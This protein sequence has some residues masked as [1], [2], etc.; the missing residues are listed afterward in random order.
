MRA[1]LYSIDP[2]RATKAI[3][4]LRQIGAEGA[5]L[6]IARQ[7]AS[8]H[9]AVRSAVV[10]A[11]GALGRNQPEIAGPALV[12]LLAD[13]DDYIRAEAADA[14]GIIGFAP[15]AAAVAERLRHDA[16]AVVRA[17]SAETLGDLGD[18][19]SVPDLVR[20]LADSDP[21]VR[22]YAA[23]AL[24][25]LGTAEIVPVLE[26]FVAVEPTPATRG[27]LL[28]ALYRLGGDEALTS[29]VQLLR[30]ADANFAPN[31]LNTIEDLISRRQPARLTADASS[32]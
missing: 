24:G 14:L 2:E 18:V 26:R 23:N 9:V 29:L 20:A 3:D 27:E 7:A 31:L 21:A 1:A 5:L 15:A 11:L 6:D 25:L 4:E 19:D 16:D 13:T 10:S 22:G 28:G 32:I 12:H 17:A 8:P 30:T